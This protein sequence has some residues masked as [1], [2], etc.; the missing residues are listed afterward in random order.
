MRR[1]LFSQPADC[2]R[3]PRLDADF[4]LDRIRD[5]AL[6][7]GALM[8]CRVRFVAWRG[9]RKGHHRPQRDTR[10][11]GPVK[12]AHCL[13]D[14]AVDDPFLLT[15]EVQEPQHMAGRQRGD[16][17]LLDR[18]STRLNSSHTVISYAVFCLKKKKKKKK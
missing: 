2:S 15:G 14:I 9:G 11:P 5:E 1:L 17:A 6:L 12:H 4:S 7:V 10:D 8:Q 13:V 3:D 16:E 18:K